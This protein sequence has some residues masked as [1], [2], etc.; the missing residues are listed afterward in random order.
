MPSQEI[1]NVKDFPAYF[2]NGEG[3]HLPAAVR[4][5]GSQSELQGKRG[6]SLRALGTYA[7]ADRVESD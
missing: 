3:R 7:K 4:L 6:Q 2:K 1:V 5:Q